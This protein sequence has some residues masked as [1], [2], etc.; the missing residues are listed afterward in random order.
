MKKILCYGD[1]NTWGFVAGS[2]DFETGGMKRHPEDVRWTSLLQEQLGEDYLIIE[3][4][5]C[6][7]NTNIGNPPELGGESC[8]GKTSLQPSL[9][10]SAP[11]NL[12]ILMLGTNDLKTAFN[13][14]VDEVIAGLEELINIIQAGLYGSDM[15]QPPKILLVSPPFLKTQGGMFADFFKGADEKS[16]LF[17]RRCA[18]LAERYRCAYL[19][20]SPHASMSAADGLHLEEAAHS[21]FAKLIAKKILL[22]EAVSLTNHKGMSGLL[23]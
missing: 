13:R 7:R 20:M 14:T 12:V 10:S 11:L 16:E 3:D 4:G 17:P 21:V 23:R 1:S 8:N 6:G 9:L 19:D 22:E 18:D 15:E 2:F 5:L